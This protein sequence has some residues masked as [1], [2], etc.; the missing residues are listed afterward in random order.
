MFKEAMD[1]LSYSLFPRRC[2]LCGEVTALDEVRCE[3]CEKL[4]RIDGKLCKICGKPKDD[5]DCKE[6]TRK[7]EYKA[8]IAPFYYENSIVAG[9]NR[10]KD[11]GYPELS[12]AM[13][14]EMAEHIKKFYGNITFDGVTFIPMSKKKELKRGYNQAELLAN[15]V[16]EN[17]GVPVIGLLEKVMK[18][19]D[20]KRG[21]AAERKM[22]LHGAFDLIQGADVDE[23]TI[24]LIDDI[25]TTGSTLNECALVLNAYGAKAV[26]A[27]AFCM[28]KSKKKEDKNEQNSK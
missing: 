24:L 19:P 6:R 25:R 17:I 12:K 14:Y 15:A 5:C 10:L 22:N 18:T 26:Y 27:A 28:A 4:E 9:V 23:K 2:E 16:S 21:S 20:Q 13:G 1:K 8:F 7:P 3:E 11:Y